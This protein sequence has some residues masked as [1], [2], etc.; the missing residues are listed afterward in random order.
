MSLLDNSDKLLRN[1]IEVNSWLNVVVLNI[2][3][4]S[5]KKG[6]E[7]EDAF[8]GLKKALV[9]RLRLLE[10]NEANIDSYIP[11]EED[12]S[13]LVL[14]EFHQ[15]IVFLIGEKATYLKVAIMLVNG[16]YNKVKQ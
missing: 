11:I 13:Y 5:D 12:L 1:Y 8:I 4:I 2:S 9:T 10:L 3:T 15:S 16:L 7:I 14:K 6:F